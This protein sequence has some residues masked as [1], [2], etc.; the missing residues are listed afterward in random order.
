M[1]KEIKFNLSKKKIV[2]LS[3]L[4]AVIMLATTIGILIFNKSKLNS[5]YSGELA[6]SMQYTQ[7]EDGDENIYD[8]D[9]NIVTEFVKFDA[10]FLRDITGD[11]YAEKLRGSARKIGESD[12]LYMELNVLTNGYLKEGATI[13][14]NNDNFY[15]QSAIPKDNEVKENAIGNNIKEIKLNQINN[16]TQKL[17]TGITCSGDY[18]YTSSKA[19]AI[20]SDVSKYSRVNTIT[21][22][23]THVAEDGTETPFEKTVWFEVDWHGTTKTEIPYYLAGSRNLN[24]EQNIA[25]AI[26]EE[27]QTFTVEHNLGIQEIDYKLNLKTAHIETE[28]PQLNG[29]DPISVEVIGNNTTYEYDETTRKLT[30]QKDAVVDENGILTSQAYDGI[31]YNNRYN[32]FKVKIT[33]PLEAYQTLGQNT[34]ESNL[35]VKAYYEGYNNWNSEFTNPYRSNAATQKFTLTIKNPDGTEIGRAS[36]RERV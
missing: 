29:R 5:V 25:N 18:N 33:Y 28:I 16:G 27:K 8:E 36:C 9:G 14:I 21:L 3:V 2:I 24:R 35:I 4:I 1:K 13:T 30:A 19:S 7:V 11:G 26:D 10:F 20:G 32:R 15:F 6:R 34:V 31:Y 17:L 23:G 12:T 22:R